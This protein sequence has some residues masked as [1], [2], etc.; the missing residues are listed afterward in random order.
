MKKGETEETYPN[1]II[2]GE[3]SWPAFINIFTFKKIIKPYF[4]D[5]LIPK[6]VRNMD[7]PKKVNCGVK[8]CQ[9][10]NNKMCKAEKLDVNPMHDKVDTSGET[11]CSTFK[12][13]SMT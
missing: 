11:Q 3:V 5:T 12:K 9:Y 13:E 1:K 8:E 10:N 2:Y 6:V 7:A 4:R